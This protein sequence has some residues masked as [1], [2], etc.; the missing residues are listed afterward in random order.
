MTRSVARSL[1]DSWASCLKNYLKLS[2]RILWNNCP[3]RNCT[4]FPLMSTILT[5]LWYFKHDNPIAFSK[6]YLL[7]SSLLRSLFRLSVCLTVCDAR[8]M[9]VRADN[10]SV[11]HGSWVKWVNI[12]GWV[13]PGH[14]SVSVTHWPTTESVKCEQPYQRL[15][16]FICS[17]LNKTI[18]SYKFNL[19]LKCSATARY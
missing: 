6:R 11:G 5:K 13:T 15:N 7:N 18:T 19:L 16:Y 9:R 14:R 2:H 17:F 4:K 3:I 8:E 1:C 10:G 12:S